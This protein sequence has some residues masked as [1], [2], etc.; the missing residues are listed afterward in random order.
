MCGN[1]FKKPK[2]ETPKVET[3]PAT[4]QVEAVK[5]PDPTPVAVTE[6]AQNATDATKKDK[7][8][9]RGYQATRVAADRGVLTDTATTNNGRQTLG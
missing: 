3:P 6:V 4:A 7:N 5:V 9:R 8:K 2:V 1:P